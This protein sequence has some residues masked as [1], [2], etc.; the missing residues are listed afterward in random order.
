MDGEPASA[1]TARPRNRSEGAWF[2]KR[3]RV[4]A[5][6]LVAR[7]LRCRSCLLFRLYR[8]S[9]RLQRAVV[10]H[11]RRILAARHERSNLLEAEPRMSKGYGVAL[12]LGQARHMD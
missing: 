5:A 6:A 3:R 12:P 11:L 7:G 1:T 9:Q 2:R 10:Q 4:V 8:L